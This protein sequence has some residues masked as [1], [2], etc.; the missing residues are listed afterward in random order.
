[1][2]GFLG[3]RHVVPFRLRQPGAFWWM[4]WHRMPDV[5]VFHYNLACYERQSGNH[6]AARERLKRAFDLEPRYRIKAL[7]DEDLEGRH[8]GPL[9]S[10]GLL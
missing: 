2:D 9:H 10:R 5:T 6:E 7:E 3:L 4:R 8:H 1:M